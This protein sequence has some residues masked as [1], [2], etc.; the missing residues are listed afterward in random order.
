M[1]QVALADPTTAA[2]V[3][4]PSATLPFVGQIHN[5]DAALGHAGIVGIKTGTSTAAGGCF[6]FA[7]SVPVAGKPQTVIGVILGMPGPQPSG[8]LTATQTLLSSAFSSLKPVTVVPKG[9][10]VARV[11]TPWGASSPLVTAAPVTLTVE[12]GMKA[13]YHLRHLSLGQ[14]IDPGARIG[15]LTVAVGTEKATVPLTATDAVGGPS[16]FWRVTHF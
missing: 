15:A 12:P 10:P 13:S 11:V 4:E 7:A 2:I 5:T 14:A 6:L 9:A 16:F 1:A 8:V 3:A